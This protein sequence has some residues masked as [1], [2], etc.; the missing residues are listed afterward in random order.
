MSGYEF[1]PPNG[2]EFDPTPPGAR[3]ERG[4]R[5]AMSP[6][7]RRQAQ[8][9]A[10]KA[11][12]K[13]AKEQA[14]AAKEQA[15]AEKSRVRAEQAQL[16]AEAKAAMAEAKAR[17]KAA[18]KAQ[19]VAPPQPAQEP[20]VQAPVVQAPPPQVSAPQPNPAP[21][22]ASPFAGLQQSAKAASSRPQ[23]PL[24]EEGLLLL[25]LAIVLAIVIKAFFVQAFYIP[26]E[27]M[28]PGFV[29]NDRI[30]VQ[31]VSYWFGGEPQRGDIVVFQDPGNWL[32]I[33]TAVG[34]SNLLTTAM[35]KIGLYPSGGHLVKRVIG[36]A[37]DVVSCCDKQGRIR[38]NHLGMDEET[39][40]VLR[41]GAE[42][43]GPMVGNCKWRAGPIPEGHVFVMGDNRA[44]SA[45][46]TVHMCRENQTDCVP[47]EEF[48]PT[49]L[50]VGKVFVL[51]WPWDRFTWIKRP[52]VFDQ[53]P[54]PDY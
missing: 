43:Y 12:A 13:A 5:R 27:S 11:Q 46:S 48:V 47:G 33:A 14:R 6:R 25:G 41:D 17:D 10:E 2:H 24:R 34:P 45:D 54:P 8:A 37:G 35:S 21:A 31:K 39:Y 42:C 53:V 1:D 50:I 3:T 32:N 4:R 49:D 18:V 38:I 40:A 22:A 44:N 28:E 30:L 23:K 29:Q 26:S 20:V 19:A 16:Q 51:L 9:R 15:R 7:E 36:V 52:A